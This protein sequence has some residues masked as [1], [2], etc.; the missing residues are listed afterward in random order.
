VIAL[1]ALLFNGLEVQ[2]EFIKNG[3]IDALLHFMR[4][5]DKMY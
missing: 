4:K 5:K 1:P 3:G 2:K